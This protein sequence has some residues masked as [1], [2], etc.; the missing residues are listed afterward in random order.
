MGMRWTRALPY[1]NH[2]ACFGCRKMFR[3]PPSQDLPEAIRKPYVPECPECRLPM[4]NM[5]KAFTPPRQNKVKLWREIESKYWEWHRK[6]ERS[7]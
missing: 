3:K 7:S 2:F 1:K 4:H 6:T 5:G